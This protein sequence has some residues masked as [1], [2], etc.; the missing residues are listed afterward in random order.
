MSGID[1]AT[2][3]QQLLYIYTVDMSGIDNV[4]VLQQLLY[5]YTLC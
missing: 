5:I 4:T 2:A 3:L 1:N